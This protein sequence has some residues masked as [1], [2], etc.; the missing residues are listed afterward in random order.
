MIYC[1]GGAMYYQV[2][3]RTDGRAGCELVI[4]CVNFEL[5]NQIRDLFWE[6]RGKRFTAQD[7][8]TDFPLPMPFAVLGSIAKAVLS[9]GNVVDTYDDPNNNLHVVFD[10]PK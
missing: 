6:F 9:F 10:Q 3:E 1:E 5:A 2:K 4:V 7:R 8:L